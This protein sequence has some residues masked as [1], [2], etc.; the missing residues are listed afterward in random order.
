MEKEI[1]LS[2]GSGG[3]DYRE[4]VQEVFLPAY[5][6]RE[7][8]ELGDSALCAIDRQARIALTTDGF[9][10]QPLFFPGGDIGSLCV[11]GTVN[12]LAVAGAVPRYLSVSMILEAGLPV[13]TLR[14][15]S[16]SIARTARQ[17]GVAVVTGDTKVV[18]HGKGDGIYVVTSGVG[19]LDG[20]WELP[21][22]RVSPGD[23]LI[24]TGPMA[25]HGM[26]ILAAR[27]GLAF[28]P[29]PQSDARP[30]NHLLASA[31]EGGATVHA[32]RDPT[33]GGVGATL[34]EWAREDV[35]LIVRETAIPILPDIAAISQL[36]GMDPLFSANEGVAVIAAP[37]DQA[38]DLLSRLRAHPDGR[39]AAVIGEVTAGH[40][41]VYCETELG[42]RR[43]LLL[44]RGELLPRIC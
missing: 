10:V 18:E 40:G 25:S 31:L 14:R 30:I 26:S 6:S 27:E 15:I 38:D 20:G 9:V 32:M 36:L 13:D 3:E 41:E 12:D 7:L 29:V 1:H 44:P 11:S 5:G 4:L 43:R 17:A 8:K 2:H 19:T 21:P 22:Q 24:L 33:R 42:T 35:S 16:E 37:R 23:V 39:E 34:C 28:S